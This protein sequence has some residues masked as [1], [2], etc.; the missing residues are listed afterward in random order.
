[1]PHT[2]T[3]DI[4]A[5]VSR[6]RGHSFL[7]FRR[8]YLAVGAMAFAGV[9]TSM[10][11]LPASAG[12]IHAEEVVASFQYLHTSLVAPIPVVARGNFAITYFSI[13]QSPVPPGTRIGKRF[14]G[15]HQ[16]DDF[17]PGLGTPVLA[18]ADGVVTQIGEPS[19]S[20]GVHVVIQHT[21][22]GVTVFSTY[23][24]MGLGTMHLSVGDTV[25]RGD[26]VGNVGSTGE[27][28]GPHLHFQILDAAGTPINPL[29]WLA[30]HVN[31]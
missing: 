4:V 22:D 15:G 20:L 7:R 11:T 25:T 12:V 2:S 26:I 8:R 16:G 6:H 10:P 28:T 30:Q 3:D 9:M 13:V 27:S 19:G 23:S 18:I 17:L 5:P 1:L 29:A 24:H 14:S 31:I 21:I